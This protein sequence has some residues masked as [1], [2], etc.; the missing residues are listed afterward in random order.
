[1]Q[2]MTSAWGVTGEV[3]SESKVVVISYIYF[4]SSPCWSL[5]LSLSLEVRP[6][7]VIYSWLPTVRPQA[8]DTGVL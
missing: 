2:C 4:S 1:M 7:L 6:N 5:S 3:V 8:F